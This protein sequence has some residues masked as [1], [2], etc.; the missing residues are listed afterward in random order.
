MNSIV[1]KNIA[2]ICE[3]YFLILVIV[4][5]LHNLFYH[6]Q[7]HIY[8]KLIGFTLP[9]PNGIPLAFPNCCLIDC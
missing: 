8:L 3:K 9:I 6:V 4:F 2:Q 7:I 1:R 5:L